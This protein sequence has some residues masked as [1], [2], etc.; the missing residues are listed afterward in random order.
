MMM[1]LTK[2]KTKNKTRRNKKLYT[3]CTCTKR[4]QT[5]Y[6]ILNIQDVAV[7]LAWMRIGMAIN[8]HANAINK[9][10][11]MY[12]CTLYYLF[13]FII[14]FVFPSFNTQFEL[15]SFMAGQRTCLSSYPPTD[16]LTGCVKFKPR[17]KAKAQRYRLNVM[18]I[19][20]W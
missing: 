2:I 6:D 4:K 13:T 8:V 14:L 18:K 10:S 11:I 5:K 1:F 12:I 19:K 3:M 20:L 9:N 17:V 7:V 16:W 15:L